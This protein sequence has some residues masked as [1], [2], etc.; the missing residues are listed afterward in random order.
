[1][2]LI[3]TSDN[4]LEK[5]IKKMKPKDF[6][7]LVKKI[8]REYSKEKLSEIQIKTEFQVKLKTGQ[9]DKEGIIIVEK[10]KK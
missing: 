2:R 8:E 7:E 4:P 9:K 3:P 10:Y 6:I 5:A 1:M